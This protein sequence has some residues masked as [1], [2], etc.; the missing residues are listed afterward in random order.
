MH[1]PD[2]IECR[3]GRTFLPEIDI[4]GMLTREQ[5]SAVDRA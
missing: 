3:Q 4:R 5:Q 1:P 2:G